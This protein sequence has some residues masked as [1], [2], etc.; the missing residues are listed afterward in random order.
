MRRALFFI[1]LISGILMIILGIAE[2]HVH[3][4]TLPVAHIVVAVIFTLSTIL[5]LMLNRKLF[6]KYFKG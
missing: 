2:A 1:M 3:P 4:A 5:H 6:I